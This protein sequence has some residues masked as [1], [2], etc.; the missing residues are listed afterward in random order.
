MNIPPDAMFQKGARLGEYRVEGFLGRGGMGEVYLAVST[1]SG[2]SVAIK[3]LLPSVMEKK[4]D[5][6]EEFLREGRVACRINHP[7]V[8][9]VIDAGIDEAT[10]VCML[11]ME[12]IDGGT[13]QQMIDRHEVIDWEWA[14]V[15][16]LRVS[17][18]LESA[19]G[20]GI[21]HRDIKPE[22]I[23]VTGSGDIKLADLGIARCSD[24]AE[25]G[26]GRRRLIGTPAYAS[27]EQCADSSR[28]D[29]RSDIY[30]L[31]ATL[32]EILTGELPFK[33]RTPI[34]MVR[35]VLNAPT[36][37]PRSVNPQIP[38]E[39]AALVMR[40]MSRNPE[41]R[42]QSAAELSGELRRLIYGENSAP[43]GRKTEK[44]RE[45]AGKITEK[46]RKIKDLYHKI[47]PDESAKK[48]GKWMLLLAGLLVVVA[49]VPLPPPEI[50]IP[51][52]PPEDPNLRIHARI[53]RKIEEAKKRIPLLQQEVERAKKLSVQP[54]E[55]LLLENLFYDYNP[56]AVA[57]WLSGGVK[58]APERMTLE[59]ICR[60]RPGLLP[61]DAAN[62]RQ[63]A[64]LLDQNGC[65]LPEKSVA[66]LVHSAALGTPEERNFAYYALTMLALSER[67][68]GTLRRL[69]ALLPELSSSIATREKEDTFLR[70]DFERVK[71]LLE[72]LPPR[73]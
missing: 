2:R 64:A 72:T 66:L 7:S 39:V 43:A 26:S 3:V 28:V 34:E 13:V 20:L 54:A 14:L 52:S 17:E 23:M 63:C 68:C 30:S 53:K 60:V 11:V 33:G 70:E 38:P 58:V 27:P 65:V 49:V 8:I 21:V 73:A 56:A 50:Q 51:E 59:W 19:A 45:I 37:D 31:G 1:V 6:A 67:N 46:C 5:F 55:A 48:R 35:Q 9:S 61:P 25:D 40:M 16:A 22:N 29:A 18:A 42:P 44:Y 10:G 41:D 32:F 36:P 12:Y 15:I 57:E 69:G 4:P 62:A 47:V 71:W 24:S